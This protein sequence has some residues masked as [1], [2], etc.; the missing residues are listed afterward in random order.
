MLY[1]VITLT[2]I[3]WLIMIRINDNTKLR[4]AI[5]INARMEKTSLK[6][7]PKFIYYRLQRG[8]QNLFAGI[9][10]MFDFRL[11]KKKLDKP[12]II[13]PESGSL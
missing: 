9:K 2:I 4:E 13:V 8:I 12:S 6:V 1:E 5:L 11:K 7:R 10:R 3:S